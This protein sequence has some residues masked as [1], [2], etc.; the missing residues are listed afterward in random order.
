MRKNQRNS[1]VYLHG[2]MSKNYSLKFK[3]L[4]FYK[5]FLHFTLC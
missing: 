5:Y 2:A 4:F 3:K 1:A